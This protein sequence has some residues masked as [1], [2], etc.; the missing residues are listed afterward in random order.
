[1][2]VSLQALGFEVHDKSNYGRGD[3]IADMVSVLQDNL[4]S[5][6]KQGE[7]PTAGDVILIRGTGV[8]FHHLVYLT[9]DGTILHSWVASRINR[10]VESQML[11]E[12][13]NNIHSVWRFEGLQ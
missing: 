9:E 5:Q 4:F 1:L 12:W 6:K 7:A 13:W 3:N 11:P 10:V 8:C 2:V